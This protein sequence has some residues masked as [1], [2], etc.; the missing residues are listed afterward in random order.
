LTRPPSS[1]GDIDKENVMSHPQHTD[2]G[3]WSHMEAERAF[4]Q[5]ARARRRA[6]ITHR[7]LRRGA[8][9]ARLLVH[10]ARTV[11]RRS[12][13]TTGVREISLDAI[14]GTLEPGRAREF[15][16]EFR[17]S[18]RAR[19]RWLSVWIAEH[20]AAGLPPIDVVQIGDSYAIR[21]GHHRVSVA[22]ARGAVTIDAIVA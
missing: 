22:R 12:A 18:K 13:A 9:C 11:P 4:G 7:L 10:D 14:S 2:H 19:K 17:P 5:A 15:D 16:R 21:D 8:D 1:G 20:T 3:A 6:S